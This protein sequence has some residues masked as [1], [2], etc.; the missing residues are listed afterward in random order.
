MDGAVRFA[1][2]VH[3]FTGEPGVG[4]PGERGHRGFGSD[5]LTVDGAIF[6]MVV[7]GDLVLKLPARR[8]AALVGSGAGMPFVNGAGRPMREWAAITGGDPGAD[9]ELA[10]EALGHVRSPQS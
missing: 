4:L 8:V 7:R 10:R 6:A 5:A 1:A 2:L 9:L 3:A